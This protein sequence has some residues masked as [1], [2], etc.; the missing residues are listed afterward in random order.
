MITSLAI[1]APRAFSSK[2]RISS[3]ACRRSAG[4]SP[5]MVELRIPPTISSSGTAA[6]TSGLSPCP[7]GARCSADSARS[8]SGTAYEGDGRRDGGGEGGTGGGGAGGVRLPAPGLGR[9][10]VALEGRKG[11]SP[12][13]GMLRSSGANRPELQRETRHVSGDVE[14]HTTRGCHLA[15]E[16]VRLVELEVNETAMHRNLPGC[17]RHR[18]HLDAGQLQ[19]DV[20][21][22]LLDRRDLQQSGEAAP[23]LFRR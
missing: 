12:P 6:V 20:V 1:P 18:G 11:S 23:H 13:V 9:S 7:P 10:T 17:D 8:V 15:P 21:A 5:R 2:R 14:R 19:I 4:T 3:S 16:L 22:D